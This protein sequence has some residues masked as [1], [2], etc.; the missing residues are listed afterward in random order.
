MRSLG[1]AVVPSA[2][3]WPVVRLAAVLCRLRQAVAFSWLRCCEQGTHWVLPLLMEALY[4][5]GWKHCGL[6]AGTPLLYLHGWKHSG[7]LEESC[8]LYWHGAT[9]FGEFCGRF[10]SPE[11][12]QGGT[13]LSL[14]AAMSLLYWQGFTHLLSLA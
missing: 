5:H 9:H 6:L 7:L 1:F 12:G 13:H 11:T 14:L 2:L 8:L 10:C 4:G 3:V